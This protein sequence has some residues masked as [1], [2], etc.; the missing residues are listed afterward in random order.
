[1]NDGNVKL[2][3]ALGC[4]L[5]ERWRAE[6]VLRSPLAAGAVGLSWLDLCNRGERLQRDET[7]G[8]RICAWGDSSHYTGSRIFP[9]LAL[10]LLRHVLAEWP[11]SVSA[12]T[13]QAEAGLPVVSIVIPIGGTERMPQFELALEAA[14]S[15]SGVDAEV[16]VVEQSRESLLA[17][18]LPSDVRYL[19]Q[20]VEGAGGFNKS[21]ALNAG[22]RIARG[23]SLI[24][25]DGD[26]LLPQAFASECARV[27]RTKE[28]A[29]PARW[30]FYLDAE[31]TG[32]LSESR[33]PRRIAGVEAIVSNNPTPI[34]VRRDTYWE[35][36]GHDESYVGWGGEDTEFLDR[37]RTRDISEGG[38]MPVLHA[39]HRAAAKKAD[40]D[41]NAG[42]H[43][44]VMESPAAQRIQRLLEMAAGPR[45]P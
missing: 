26:Y 21:Q 31:S 9:D 29:R 24:I 8:G 44:R 11:L 2:R 20:S 10:R 32:A 38:W 36:G 18:R 1:M 34:A 35:I 14:R 5:N 27:L 43:R 3:Q 17:G 4:W 30:I 37:L 42:Q 25:L 13:A 23:D 41:R 6:F 7:S 15:Q 40:G 45:N 22:A 39:W 16:I 12:R 33:D 28:A 19:H